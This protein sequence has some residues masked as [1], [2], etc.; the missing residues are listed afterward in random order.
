MNFENTAL[1]LVDLQ[2][3]I[4]NHMQTEPHSVASVLNNA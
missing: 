3:G 2:K 4:A 1:V